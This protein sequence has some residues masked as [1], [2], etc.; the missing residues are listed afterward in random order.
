MTFSGDVY[1]GTEAA[2]VVSLSWDDVRSGSWDPVRIVDGDL[3]LPSIF[4]VV[5]VSLA[6]WRPARDGDPTEPGEERRGWWFDPEFGSRLW[7]LERANNTPATRRAA[8]DYAEEA[9]AWL[10]DEGAAS[11]VTVTVEDDDDGAEDLLL[12]IRIQRPDAPDLL[13]RFSDLWG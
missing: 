6:S 13:A 8:R 4:D 5:V 1:E 2:E 11:A 9:L 7:L 10:V 12:Q 3:A